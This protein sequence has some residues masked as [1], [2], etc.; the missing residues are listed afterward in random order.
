VANKSVEH[1]LGAWENATVKHHTITGVVCERTEAGC[2]LSVG[3]SFHRRRMDSVLGGLCVLGVRK[4]SA[5]TKS[6]CDLCVLCGYI[7]KSLSIIFSLR[8]FTLLNCLRAKCKGQLQ[9][10]ARALKT[11]CCARPTRFDCPK[12]SRLM[13]GQFP[14][15]S[16]DKN[17]IYA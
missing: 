10:V 15:H 1:D 6:L 4:N 8:F 13:G 2:G 14:P 17:T 12:R 7:E 9:R 3:Y 16:P 11:I 5:K